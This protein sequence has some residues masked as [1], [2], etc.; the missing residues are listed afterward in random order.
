MECSTELETPDPWIS[1]HTLLP[2]G[3]AVLGRVPLATVLLGAYLWESAENFVFECGGQ[4]EET[5]FNALILDPLAATCA[6]GV[7]WPLVAAAPPPPQRSALEWATRLAWILAPS[8]VL[9]LGE[10]PSA[11]AFTALWCAMVTLVGPGDTPVSVRV[12]LCGFAAVHLAFVQYS[13]WP[14]T[15]NAALCALASAA[16]LVLPRRVGPAT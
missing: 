6:L 3:A 12:S 13:N 8:V 10:E 11:A 2:L 15:R 14:H 1:T 5:V 4:N 9:W 7:A 16:G